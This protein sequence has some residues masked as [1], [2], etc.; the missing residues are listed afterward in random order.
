[1]QATNIHINT[2]LYIGSWNYGNKDV[3]K[4]SLM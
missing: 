3:I 1:M 4:F 2:H